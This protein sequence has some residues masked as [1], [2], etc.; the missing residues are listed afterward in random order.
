MREVPGVGGHRVVGADAQ[1]DRLGARLRLFE[2]FLFLAEEHT[3]R[4]LAF[5]A[6]VLEPV[7]EQRVRLATATGPSEEDVH[8]RALDQ[9]GLRARL[10]CP[11]DLARYF[12]DVVIAFFLVHAST[13]FIFSGTPIT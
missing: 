2:F 9:R 7:A 12:R 4:V 5:G 1:E 6:L 3:A 10:G 8:D 11:H 13:S